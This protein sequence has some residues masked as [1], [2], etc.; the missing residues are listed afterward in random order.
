M[1]SLLTTKT[2]AIALVA[3]AIS[4]PGAAAQQDLRSPDT[5]DAAQSTVQDLRSPD[6]RDA[7]QS[8]VQDLRS[9]DARDAAIGVA[10]ASAA[11]PEP[12]SSGEGFDWASAGI[13]VAAVGGVLLMLLG[14]RTFGRHHGRQLPV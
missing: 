5:R 4:A 1:R 8:T 7:A 11:T 2:L 12:V 9:P 3:A 13:G 14:L 6:T 10:T